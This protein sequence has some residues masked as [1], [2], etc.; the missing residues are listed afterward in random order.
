MVP[1]RPGAPRSLPDHR[2]GR[3]SI[4][5]TILLAMND[6]RERSGTCVVQIVGVADGQSQ[7]NVPAVNSA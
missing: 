4:D 2:L 3:V 5:V 1:T 6:R 7:P